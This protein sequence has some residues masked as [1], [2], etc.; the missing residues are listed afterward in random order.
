ME[1]LPLLIE[2]A[3]DPYRTI[4]MALGPLAAVGISAGSAL[5]NHFLNKPSGAEEAALR[6]GNEASSAQ[7][8]ELR[9]QTQSRQFL[10]DLLK[11]NLESGPNIDPLSLFKFPEAAGGSSFTD[12][13][14][15]AMMTATNQGAMLDRL[16]GLAGAPVGQGLASQSLAAGLGAE[17]NQRDS[18]ESLVSNIALALLQGGLGG[19]STT[20]APAATTSPGLFIN[21]L[22][23][24]PV[25]G[26]GTF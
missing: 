24:Q 23:G 18:R 25:S 16:L 5:L 4:S 6:T 3:L 9:R 21:P 8:A 12:E 17:Q 2:T 19:G 7:A 26:T 22:T 15:M 11:G 10:E 20:S 1:F 13:Q 14:L